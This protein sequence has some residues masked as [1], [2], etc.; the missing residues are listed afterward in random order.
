MVRTKWH[1]QNGMDKIVY[2]PN[3]SG[4]NGIDIMVRTKWFEYKWVRIKSSIHQS[5][6]HRRYDL[7][8][9]NLASNFTSLGFLCVFITY[10]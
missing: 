4:Q 10:L 9:I 3:G 6:T 8:F 2:G 7:F 5:H 1:G